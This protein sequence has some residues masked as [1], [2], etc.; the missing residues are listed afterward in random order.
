MNVI[1]E[2][3]HIFIYIIFSFI[4]QELKKALMM[5]KVGESEDEYVINEADDMNDYVERDSDSGSVSILHSR[6][7]DL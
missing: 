6:Y 7:L 1:Y 2:T 3:S 5:R 4:L